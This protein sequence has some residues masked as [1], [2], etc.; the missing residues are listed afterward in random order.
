MS[1]TRNTSRHGTASTHEIDHIVSMLKS[2]APVR[3]KIVVLT[4]AHPKHI[5]PQRIAIQY[6]PWRQRITGKHDIMSRRNKGMGYLDNPGT[7]YSSISSVYANA[8]CS[9]GSKIKGA[10]PAHPRY[11][12]VRSQK[13]KERSTS[14][15]PHTRSFKDP[16]SAVST[17]VLRV[18]SF[19]R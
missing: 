1:H 14:R 19:I 18:L 5:D 6:L 10:K 8:V 16:Y 13:L 7:G 15:H 2:G 3:M 4:H 12:R 11:E 9:I 17:L